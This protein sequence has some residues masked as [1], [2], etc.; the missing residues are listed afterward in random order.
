MQPTYAELD[1]RGRRFSSSLP[2]PGHMELA[3]RKVGLAARLGIGLLSL[4]DESRQTEGG[5]RITN[6]LIHSVSGKQDTA[7][8]NQPR[9]TGPA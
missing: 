5:N 3:P 8:P 4:G 9:V 2:I 7:N 1:S 6:H